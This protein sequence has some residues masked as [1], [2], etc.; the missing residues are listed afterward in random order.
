MFDQLPAPDERP[1]AHA[2]V[3]I[4]TFQLDFEEERALKPRDGIAWQQEFKKRGHKIPR[5]TS[6]KQQAINVSI[7]AGRAERTVSSERAGWQ[8]FFEDGVSNAALFSTG[9]NLEHFNYEGYGNLRRAALDAFDAA[10]E[11]LAP[12]VQQ[13]ITLSYSNALSE[14]DAKSVDYWRGKIRRE[15]LGPAYEPALSENLTRSFTVLS[16]SEADYSVDMQLAIQPDQV[17]SGSK[18][19]VFQTEAVRK[20]IAPLARTEVENTVDALHTIALKLFTA[21]LEPAYLETLRGNEPVEID[22]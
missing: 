11:L 1:L 21:V 16:W 22:A 4:A 17:F 15:F 3:Q 18:A 6:V 19:F 9:V 8:V 2:P 20:G 10:A 12:Q 13:R 14:E 5:L 7:G